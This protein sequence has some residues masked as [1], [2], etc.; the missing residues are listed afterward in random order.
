MPDSNQDPQRPGDQDNITGTGTGTGPGTRRGFEGLKVYALEH[1]IDIAL[2][3]TRALTLLFC[4]SYILPIFGSASSSYQKALMS[5]AASSA[6]RLHQR[7]P[8]IQFTRESFVTLIMED[9]A[10]YLFY[11][12]IFMYSAPITMV[13]VPIFLF[14]LLHFASFTLRLLDI[15]GRNNAL[16]S[17]FLISLVEF[18]QRNMLRGAAFV[19]IFLMPLAVVSVFMGRVS[20]LTPVLYY[21]FLSM[22]YSS[23]RN[24]YTRTMFYELRMSATYAVDRPGVPQFIRSFVH[25]IITFTSSLAP[26]IVPSQN[27]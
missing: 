22:R 17:R 7:I 19:E 12:I 1:K 23:R 21:R 6:L 26:P 15:L 9:S 16:L 20:L 2:W 24:A 4:F 11:S 5:N 3:A 25:K 18:Q 13:L 10:H 27:Q 14:A 8:S